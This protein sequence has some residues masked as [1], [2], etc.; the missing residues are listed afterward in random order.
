[1]A[2]QRAPAAG[3]AA[4]LAHGHDHPAP[5]T[6]QPATPSDLAI[7]ALERPVRQLR[8]LLLALLLIVIAA[9][10][11]AAGPLD[12]SVQVALR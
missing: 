12:L 3:A 9:A 7:D 10:A 4:Q 1:M 11:L 6:L 5:L 8:W 2:Y